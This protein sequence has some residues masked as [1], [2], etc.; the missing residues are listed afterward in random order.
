M[1]GI[2][3]LARDTTAIFSSEVLTSESGYPREVVIACEEL[4][5]RVTP[6][7]KEIFIISRARPWGIEIV[8]ESAS[9]TSS[10]VS[11]RSLK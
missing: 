11:S 4:H 1:I 10:A 3:W 6:D 5:A 9:S 2:A 8:D 7:G